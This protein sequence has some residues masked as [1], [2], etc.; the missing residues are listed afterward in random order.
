M[1]LVAHVMEDGALLAS[2]HECGKY[3]LPDE[4]VH[5]IECVEQGAN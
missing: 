4:R 2:S 1:N 5:L 3:R